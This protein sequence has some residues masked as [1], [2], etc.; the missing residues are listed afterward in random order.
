MTSTG[1]PAKVKRAK[2]TILYACIG[3]IV[4]ALAYAIVNWTIS[5]IGGSGNPPETSED[6][7]GDNSGGGGG[8]GST[9]QTR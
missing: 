6:S 5:A 4:C 8:G 2:D 7:E 1:D 3:L 9:Q